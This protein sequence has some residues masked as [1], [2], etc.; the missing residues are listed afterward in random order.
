MNFLLSSLRGECKEIFDSALKA[1]DPYVSVLSHI[2]LHKDALIISVS[3]GERLVVPLTDF[4]RVIVVG[5]GKATAPMAEAIES[6]LNE[7]ISEG[8]IVVKD[9]HLGKLSRITQIEASHPLPD[10][11]CMQAASGIHDLLQSAGETDLIISLI[12]GGGSSLLAL[13]DD[14]PLED[15]ISVTKALLSCG[16][17]IGEINCI[18]KHLSRVKGGL[19]AKA[20]FPARV[21]NCLI[22]DVVGDD[23]SSIASGPFVPD[24]STFFDAFAILKK[25]ELVDTVPKTVIKRISAGTQ[26]DIPETPKPGDRMFANVTT[27]I[28]ASNIQSLISAKQCAE[29]FGYH[30]TILSSMIEGDT[31][32]AALFHG[33]IAREIHQSGNPLPRPACV[34]SGGETTV[35][36]KGKGMG[37]RNMEFALRA[38][39]EISGI[40]DMLIASF[41]T[42]G[43]DGPTDAA[44]AFADGTTIER[45]KKLGLAAESFLENNDSYHFF[46]ALGDLV[47]T[48]P[49]KTNVMDFRMILAR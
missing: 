36:I 37:G 43:T 15:K 18:R 10:K 13:P 28:L 22:S 23:I 35:R 24:S 26:G 31:S 47:K 25:Y 14:I 12:S 20:A 4:T 32:E 34:I 49:T 6:L 29:K 21:I 45:A 19:L 42:D 44:G 5:A 1:A 30:T 38:A 9:G 2:S 27:A 17:S 46:E 8:I 41:G 3:E 39:M 40:P 7:R 48:G 16:A 11:R 33:R